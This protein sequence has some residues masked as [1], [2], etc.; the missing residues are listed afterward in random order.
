[1]RG[2]AI[3]AA[4]SVEGVP[5]LR[6]PGTI[7]HVRNLDPNIVRGDPADGSRFGRRPLLRDGAR[8]RRRPERGIPKDDVTDQPGTRGFDVRVRGR[9]ASGERV[10]PLDRRE[11]PGEE[12]G[13]RARSDQV[14]PALRRQRGRARLNS[15]RQGEKEDDEPDRETDPQCG[16]RRPTGSATQGVERVTHGRPRSFYPLADRRSS[17]NVT[18]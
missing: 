13:V 1:M 9:N 18:S 8:V 10:R 4:P 7:V 12:S 15:L 11:L 3:V 14:D 16:H 5:R 6:E 17:P 2:G